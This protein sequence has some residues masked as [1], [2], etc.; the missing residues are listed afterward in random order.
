MSVLGLL[1]N[2]SHAQQSHQA[3]NV[4]KQEADSIASVLTN[5]I[6][7]VSSEADGDTLVLYKYEP[8]PLGVTPAESYIQNDAST[9]ILG[10]EGGIVATLKPSP[11]LSFPANVG[12]IPIREGVSPM[13]ARTYDIPIMT[14]ADCKLSPNVSLT[15]NS[16]SGNGVAGYG[17]N[18]M[19][20]SAIT[21]TNKSI[22]YDGE[23]G[24]VNIASPADCVFSLDG[25]RLV[26]NLGLLY[27]YDYETS[28]G[29]ILVKKHMAGDNIAY[30][31]VAYPNGNTATFGFTDN[32]DTQPVYPITELRDTKGHLVNFLYDVSGNCHYLSKIKY[33]GTSASSHPAEIAFDYTSRKDYTTVYV[34]GIPMNPDR[35]LTKITSSDMVN[36][37][38]TVIRIYSLTHTFDEVNRLVEVGCSGNSG[39]MPSLTF[40]YGTT[41]DNRKPAL[42]Q[43][44]ASLLSTYFHASKDNRLVILR[45]KLQKNTYS[46][47]LVLLPGCFEPWTMIGKHVVNIIGKKYEFPVY[48]SSYPENQNILIA[49]SLSDW[50]MVDSIKA[51]KGFQAIQ[52]VDINGS[53]NDCIVKVNVM[54]CGKNSTIFAVTEY[55]Y[56]SGRLTQQSFTFSINRSFNNGNNKYS[57]AMCTYHWGDFYGNGKT[58][59]LIASYDQND[60]KKVWLD[61]VDLNQMK[62][63]GESLYLNDFDYGNGQ[64]ICAIDIDGDGKAELCRASSHGTDIFAMKY[65]ILACQRVDSSIDNKAFSERAVWG[66]MNGDGKLDCLVAPEKSYQNIVKRDMPVW[67]NTLCPLCG[68]YEPIT[69]NGTELCKKCGGNIKRFCIDHPSAL[70]C[71]VC[72]SNLN[73][74]Y[75]TSTPTCFVHGAVAT[76]D[77][78]L[79]FVDNG[80]KWTLYTSTGKSFV[81]SVASILQ[82][83]G[84]EQYMLM[85]FN[86]D[87]MADLIRLRG[88]SAELIVNSRG[89]LS[90]N[91]TCSVS[92]PQNTEIVPSNVCMFRTVSNFITVDGARVTSYSYSRDF[93]RQNLVTTMTDSY[94]NRHQSGYSRA[95]GSGGNLVITGALNC[96]YPYAPFIQPLNLLQYSGIVSSDGTGVYANNSYTYY[97]ALCH[98]EGLGFLGFEKVVT[99]DH[100]SGKSV[101]ET[102]DPKMLGV[103]TGVES[104]DKKSTAIYTCQSLSN[105]VRN[106]RV[107]STCETDLITGTEV[108]SYYNYD[109]YGN[110]TS[111]MTQYGDV[112]R[113]RKTIAYDNIVT[114]QLFM[115]GLQKEATTITA[116]G[117]ESWTTKVITTYDTSHMPTVRQSFTNG[118]KVSETR[119]TYDSHGNVL[120]EKTA[121]YDATEF[122]GVTY[123]Y[124]AAGR[125]VV[126]STNSLGQTTNF[127]DYDIYGN[128]GKTTDYKGLTVSYRYDVNGDVA[129]ITYAD[130]TC[131]SIVKTWGG[132]GLYIVAKYSDKD[133]SSVTHY[134]A[135]D[136]EVRSGT[137]RFDGA[138]QFVDSEY[139]SH[140]RLAKVSVPF[141]GDAAT[142]WNVYEYDSHDRPV[143]YNEASGR[144]T[145]WAY[146]GRQTT[147]TKEGIATTR[148]LDESGKLIAASD[149]GGTLNYVLRADGQPS[150]ITA[151]GNVKTTY[152]YNAYG[153]CVSVTDPSF[154]TQTFAGNYANDG[155]HTM[156]STDADGNVVT[157]SFDKY[158]RRKNE[159]RPEFSTSY[160]YDDDG[161]LIEERSTNGV[162]ITMGYDKFGRLCKK[163]KSMH[164]KF[165]EKSF[166]YTDGKLSHEA[167][168]VGC[169]MSQPK[170]FTVSY[171]YENNN[172]T[173]AVVDNTTTIWRLVSANDFGQPTEVVTGGMTRLYDFDAYGMP[174]RRR[175]GTIQDFGYRFDPRTGNL[176]S[177]TDNTRSLTETFGYDH[178]NRLMRMGD[179]T[180][181][182]ADNGNLLRMPGVGALQYSHPSKPYAVT[183]LTTEGRGNHDD[184]LDIEYNSFHCPS[185]IA[186]GGI[187][188]ELVYDAVGNRI[189]MST[190]SA[191]KFYLD[192][193]ETDNNGGMQVLYIGGDAYSAPVAC[194]KRMMSP[195][196]TIVNICRDHQGSITH[197]ANINGGLMR[198]YSY[199]AWG[200]M[201]NPKTQTAY[202]EGY[203]DELYLG[204]GYTGHEHL[205][206]YGLINMN[207]RLYDTE[208][209]R[210]LSPDPY[211]QMPDNTQNY[212]RYSYCMN[213]PLKYVDK[214]GKSILGILLIVTGMYIGAASINKSFNPL[215]WNYYSWKTYAGM[216]IGGLSAYSALNVGIV[217]YVATSTKETVFVSNFI[218]G[219][220]SGMVYESVK[221]FGI[222]IL[223]GDNIVKSLGNA[224]LDGTKGSFTGSIMFST[225]INIGLFF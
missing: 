210:F 10:K 60:N 5:K 3:S 162:L 32:I 42:V 165:I 190:G 18:V 146:D 51:E 68:Q 186:K 48:G 114:P 50:S 80:N 225:G 159:T 89:M 94:H 63:V 140:G 158:G 150:E 199:D 144:T 90:G 152:T 20:G 35:L 70:V 108:T 160:T 15:Y 209:G 201:R 28:Q 97:N 106:P 56:E 44:T 86:N 67:T 167:I 62:H 130:N 171:K 81:K 182:Y 14:A 27:E 156:T 120:S 189:M 138:W 112:Q 124:D 58:Q 203:M 198:E 119:Y 195:S 154:G 176:M 180:M 129:A 22:F 103:V 31:T 168:T 29:Y 37:V 40:E 148:T 192:E 193:Y 43:E 222:N 55:S 45:G 221:S 128:A 82:R 1:S 53:G 204:R 151:P 38:K 9:S 145:T 41:F 121:P 207:A 110:T 99:I 174:T 177:R 122:I 208:T 223:N 24:P 218:T 59:L 166:E 57:P 91:M 184:D 135:L 220:F 131:E 133:P 6:A 206:Q 49:T 202:P 88:T 93:S 13:G 143:S 8:M 164:N 157:T 92:V 139:D 137:Q 141:V 19:G 69:E 142:A 118:N 4:L 109:A 117:A 17:W 104:Q 194:V 212:N 36:G 95:F 46:D 100:I 101:T 30:F 127:S 26:E 34:D 161:N 71:R 78:D 33:G 169:G 134:D 181:E 115:V 163:L 76:C 12:S 172:M 147:E 11:A 107:T 126:T 98:K 116:R 75:G 111:A 178:L 96:A 72:H 125:H 153:H 216:L 84:D 47:G 215:K 211:V 214:D 123:T 170:T 224:V 217:T 2:V 149:A 205:T 197:I 183:D 185:L 73:V 213:N 173:E 23:V 113:E 83:F 52:A 79:G 188:S 16:Q 65:G 196:W 39:V 105:G 155:S 66:D 77:V 219:M 191:R 74:A 64:T 136:R 54:G 132:K 61:L 102:R 85:D 179:K 21:V 175:A 87:G 187:V 25:M 200:N 7:E